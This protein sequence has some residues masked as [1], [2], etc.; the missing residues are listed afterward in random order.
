MAGFSSVGSMIALMALNLAVY[1]LFDR[2]FHD[3]L[4]TIATGLVRGV[5]V[6]GEHR[7]LLLHTSW[8]E[9]VTVQISFLT[10]SAYG[11]I[12]LSGTANTEGMRVFAQLLAF[13]AAMGALGW[14]ALAPFWYFR[15]RGII[16]QAEAD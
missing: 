10:L 13:F 11:W 8:I 2:W 1:H 16:R 15:L 9:S 7:R 14:L 12:Q 4:E 5:Q 6:P 3:R